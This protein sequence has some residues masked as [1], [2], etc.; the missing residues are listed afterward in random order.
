MRTSLNEIWNDIN[1]V[2]SGSNDPITINLLREIMAKLRKLMELKTFPVVVVDT[3]DGNQVLAHA[4]GSLMSV[5]G[6]LPGGDVLVLGKEVFREV[7]ERVF[8]TATDA[9]PSA[10]DKACDIDPSV[11]TLDYDVL[12]QDERFKEMIARIVRVSLRTDLAPIA[13]FLHRVAGKTIVEKGEVQAMI[14][15][16]LNVKQESKWEELTRPYG[17]VHI[18]R[19]ASMK[20]L[21]EAVRNNEL[22]YGCYIGM[23]QDGTNR[24][25]MISAY[26]FLP[27]DGGVD[28]K[29]V[30]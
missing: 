30:V 2:A 23:A 26:N 12:S 7:Y 10:V 27:E 22:P 6:L 20:E 14:D 8:P 5:P 18:N 17:F 1:K 19:V 3:T 24:G 25:S 4:D 13:D 21:E 16:K 9:D 11:V 29:S 28:R 15:E